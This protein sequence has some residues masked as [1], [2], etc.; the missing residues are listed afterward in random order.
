MVSNIEGLAG[1]TKGTGAAVKFFPQGVRKLWGLWEKRRPEMR[2]LFRR[3]S[4]NRPFDRNSGVLKCYFRFS[5]DV[6]K[7]Q[8]NKL[9]VLLSF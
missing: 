9:S 5:H 8:T 6:I 4:A 7:I 3:L 2:L 1:F